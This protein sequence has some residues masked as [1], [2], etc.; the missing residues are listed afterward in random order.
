MESMTTAERLAIYKT[1][2][3]GNVHVWSKNKYQAQIGEPIFTNL[4]KLGKNDPY[5]LAHLMSQDSLTKDLQVLGATANFHSDADG[6]LFSGDSELR[7]P[8]LRVISSALVQ[9]M[10]PMLVHRMLWFAQQRHNEKKFFNSPMRTAAVKYLRYREAN[11]KLLESAVKGTFKRHLQDIY[12]LLGIYPSDEAAIILKWKQRGKSLEIVKTSL[13]EGLTPVQISNKIVK[14]N[15]PFAM[16]LS[17]I[18]NLTPIIG[19]A[20]ASVA[21]PRQLTIHTSTWEELGLFTDATFTKY[22]QDT[23]SKI[24]DETDRA[25]NTEK[26]GKAKDIVEEV[27]AEQRKKT[28]TH[29]LGIKKVFIHVDASGSMTSFFNVACDVAA[30][31]AEIIPDPENNLKWGM[32]NTSGKMLANPQK[33]TSGGF[34]AIMYGKTAG[35]GTDITALMPEAD[36]HQTDLNVFVTDGENTTPARFAKKQKY[37]VIVQVG[38]YSQ[39]FYREASRNF[40]QLIE[41]RPEHFLGSNLVVQAFAKAIKGEEVIIEQIMSTKLLELPRWWKFIPNR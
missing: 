31:I 6:S 18:Q 10:N 8:N 22:Y 20:L 4:L 41:M 7:K 5:F 39:T 38:N 30:K 28:F 1:I 27:R 36:K 19:K 3:A 9:Q 26:L 23:L 21:S 40:E 14:E 25:I 24:G 11:K 17:Q 29:E 16:A 35:G 12:R 15:I 37:G 2:T 32:F 34:Q 13:F 33:Y